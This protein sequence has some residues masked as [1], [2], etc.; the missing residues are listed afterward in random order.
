MIKAI[1]IQDQMNCEYICAKVQEA[2][3]EYHKHSQDISGAL[4]LI[5]IKK[6]SQETD[7]AIAKLE[8]KNHDD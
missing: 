6:P 7:E 5:D 8:Y 3:N 4:I 2:I 1:R